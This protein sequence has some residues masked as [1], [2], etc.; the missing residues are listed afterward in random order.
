V[1]GKIT[2]PDCQREDHL[3]FGAIGAD[4]ARKPAGE[5]GP[6]SRMFSPLVARRRPHSGIYRWEWS[7]L[8]FRLEDAMGQPTKDLAQLALVNPHAGGLDVGAREIWGCVPADK[9]GPRVRCFGTFT[10]DLHQLADWFVACGVDTVALEST[11]VFGIPV[12]ELLEARGLKVYLVNAR[13]IKNVPGRKS[14]VRDCQ[15]I[16]K[17]HSLGLLSSSFRP[18]AEVCRLRAYLRHRAD[19][20]QHRAPHILHMQKAL[21][22]MNMQLHHVLTDLTGVT[23]LAILRAIV[24]GERDAVKLAQL[25]D[26][27]CKS[28][29]ARIVKALRGHWKDEHLF[30]LQQSL[31]LYDS[32]TQ[33]LTACDRQIQRQF[34]AMR[35]H[36]DAPL[37]IPA[38]SKRRTKNK[39]QPAFDV[40]SE[41][42]QLT[43]V[44][45]TAVS[46]ISDSLAQTILAEIGTD[47]TRWPTVKH[48]AS[49][50][51]LAPRNDI[52]GGKVLRSRTLP[53]ANRA[54]QAF[55]QAATAVARG[56][57]AFGAYYRRKRAKS[58]PQ[59][60][61]VATAHKIARTVYF[62]LKH[63]RPFTD[64]G[65]ARADQQHRER[66]VSALRRRA[67][68]LGL[69]LSSQTDPITSSSK[70]LP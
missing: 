39:N 54:G 19:L 13:H 50:L 57:S 8:A 64:I 67:A 55:R 29:Q 25:R 42:I 11:G 53:T 65:A 40:R 26:P 20:V 44:D 61:Q 66:E 9:E 23:G 12:F 63:R 16:Q 62:L 4:I 38:S 24:A 5:H 1:L 47:M 51:G 3:K 27:H 46:G 45:L 18:D 33:Q 15:W 28:P 59:A 35:P 2:E 10:P 21:Q 17:L 31:E 22:Q 69:A 37:P 70:V 7:E 32:Y 58:G 68:Q 48:F 34:S 52:S 43:G 30:I 60:A 49:W 6:H 56:P 41:I 36:L 14:D